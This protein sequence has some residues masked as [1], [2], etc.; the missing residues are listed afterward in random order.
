MAQNKQGLPESYIQV[1][2]FIA[3]SALFISDRIFHLVDPPV[4][5]AAYGVMLVIGVLGT[6]GLEGILSNIGVLM[7]GN[8]DKDK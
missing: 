7:S 2:A 5:D 4:S 8:K 3:A 1:V 6:S